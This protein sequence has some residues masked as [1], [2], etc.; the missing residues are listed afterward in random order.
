MANCHECGVELK[1]LE[2]RAKVPYAFFGDHYKRIGEANPVELEVEVDG[3][4]CP[5]CGTKLATGRGE[6]LDVLTHGEA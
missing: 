5:M 1:Y 3:Y 6:A 4:Y 2:C